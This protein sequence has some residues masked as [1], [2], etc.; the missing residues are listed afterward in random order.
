MCP[1]FH[2]VGLFDF[3]S[4]ETPTAVDLVERMLTRKAPNRFWVTDITE[5]RT[6][7]GKVYRAVV[8]DTFSH[9]VIGW[10]IDSSQTAALT[11]KVLGM[12]IANRDP[13][14]GVMVHSDTAC[15]SR[16]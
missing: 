16:P 4:H 15:N 12:A 6:Y 8:L 14:P 1:R 13:Q 2:G 11:T 10:S 9:R 3:W 5:H 7:E